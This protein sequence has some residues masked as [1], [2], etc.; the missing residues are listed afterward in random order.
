VGMPAGSQ[1]SYSSD[2]A[3]IVFWNLIPEVQIHSL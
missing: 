2:F 1:L 3:K